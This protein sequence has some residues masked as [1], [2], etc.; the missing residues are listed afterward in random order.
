MGKVVARDRGTVV[1]VVGLRKKQMLV[2]AV[3]KESVEE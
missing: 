3:G 2:T 1:V